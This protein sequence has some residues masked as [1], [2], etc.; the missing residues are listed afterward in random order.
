MK[1]TFPPPFKAKEFGSWVFQPFS[2]HAPHRPFRSWISK[3]SLPF[4]LLAY[5]NWLNYKYFLHSSLLLSFFFRFSPPTQREQTCVRR[6][7]LIN[8]LKFL[9]SSYSGGNNV[10]KRK[11]RATWALFPRN[12]Y[13]WFLCLTLSEDGGRSSRRWKEKEIIEM[14]KKCDEREINFRFFSFSPSFN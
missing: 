8:I 6:F 7:E 1:R 3:Y 2:K 12:V 5:L 4:L 13:I 9:S 10:S 11:A 14:S